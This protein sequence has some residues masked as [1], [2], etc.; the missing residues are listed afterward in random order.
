MRDETTMR[1][2]V[3]VL[4]LAAGSCLAPWPRASAAEPEKAAAAPQAAA[5][6][7]A[8]PNPESPEARAIR[9]WE[10]IMSGKA[11][12][13]YDL[14]SPGARSAKSREKYATEISQTPV[15]W[16]AVSL[17]DKACDSA[18]ACQVRLEIS[19]TAPLQGARGG[20]AKSKSYVIERWV[21]VDR[22]WFFVPEEYVSGGL[23]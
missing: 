11:K 17:M 22:K 1:N 12:Q 2:L 14:L 23:H 18:D 10:L 16:N 7:A 21:R 8:K 20:M 13:A 3:L 19:F 4:T 9:R 15:A 6:A 5:P